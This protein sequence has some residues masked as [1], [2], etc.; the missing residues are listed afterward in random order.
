M[1]YVDR[2]RAVR[3]ARVYRSVA[4]KRRI[5][6]LTLLP[7]ASVSRVAQAEGVNSHQ[8]FDWRRAYRNGKLAA[9]EQESCKLLP[10]IVSVPDAGID[11]ES[12]AEASY[13]AV[14]TGRAPRLAAS[15]AHAQA[16]TG[17]IHIELPG[18]ATFRVENGVN[19][20]LLRAVMA[21]LRS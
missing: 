18:G 12:T 6:E 13:G 1:V 14:D 19:A 16:A 3:P 11:A 5:V 4:E 15:S 7:G 20:A 9:G 10:V 8:V 21:S 2:K 17:S